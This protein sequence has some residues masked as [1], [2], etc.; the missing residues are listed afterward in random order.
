MMNFYALELDCNKYYVGKTS[1]DVSTR[2]EEH[3]YDNGSQWTAF[4]KPI[5]IIEHYQSDSQFEEDILTKKYMIKYGIDNV[6]GGSYTKMLLDDWQIKSL[7][8]EFKSVSDCCY[9]CGKQG[10]FAN[11]CPL[12]NFQG[13]NEELE[14]KIT[15][16]E[17]IKNY[18][19]NIKHQQYLSEKCVK[20]YLYDTNLKHFQKS[21]KTLLLLN[22][23]C[24]ECNKQ[25]TNIERNLFRKKNEPEYLL[26]CKK[27]D[28]AYECQIQNFK[29][30]FEFLE[31]LPKDHCVKNGE[32]CGTTYSNLSDNERKIQMYKT[33]VSNAKVEKKYDKFI[34]S[35]STKFKDDKE[36]IEYID[37]MLVKLW[38]QLAQ[39][40]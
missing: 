35:T 20:R 8:H 11:A 29:V 30:T 1:R 4:Y 9:N 38:R 33:F 24:P 22:S 7:Q 14:E 13:T 28:V 23:I 40:I 18:I 27:C 10:H 16:L 3:K 19:Q 36:T 21:I 37:N 5:K 34:E 39:R 17:D 25:F 12:D 26:V 15:E 6:R 31:N 2:F 32:I